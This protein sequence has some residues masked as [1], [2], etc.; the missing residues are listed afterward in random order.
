M[1]EIAA[2]PQLAISAYPDLLDLT[3]F[4]SLLLMKTAHYTKLS[5]T[6]LILTAHHYEVIKYCGEFRHAS[7]LLGVIGNLTTR[8]CSIFENSYTGALTGLSKVT[9]VHDNPHVQYS[10]S[11]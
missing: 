8:S 9:N 10:V 3:Y 2:K 5:N 11:R 6:Q 7:T 4:A 1:V